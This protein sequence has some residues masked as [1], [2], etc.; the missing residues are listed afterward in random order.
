M[1][2]TIRL[3]LYIST[4]HNRKETMPRPELTPRNFPRNR[5]E[6]APSS[7]EPSPWDSLKEVK[8]AGATSA[9]KPAEEEFVLND[10]DY[11]VDFSSWH[12]QNKPA[13]PATANNPAAANTTGQITR[14]QLDR[15]MDKILSNTRDYLRQA[16]ERYDKMRKEVL[17]ASN[18]AE[19]EIRRGREEINKMFDQQLAQPTSTPAPSQKRGFSFFR[20]SK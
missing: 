10:D 11:N 1:C 15:D 2:D 18:S 19:E 5:A 12:T 8:F 13:K 6:Q 9:A 4:N 7:S 3:T 14:E 16:P 20:R 17:G